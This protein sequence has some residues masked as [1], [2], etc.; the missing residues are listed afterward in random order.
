MPREKYRRRPQ[1]VKSVIH[2]GQRKLLLSE[3][4]FLTMYGRDGDVV[5]HAGAAPGN[6]TAYLAD[7]FSTMNFVLVDPAPFSP[8]LK[9]GEKMILR[10]ELFTDE[11]AHEYANQDVLFICDIRST[12]WALE[13]ESVVEDKVGGDME[14]QMRWH[15]IMKPRKSMLKFRLS[16]QP[17]TTEY[18]AGDMYLPVWG[19]ITTTEARLIPSEGLTMYD[20]KAYE[21]RVFFFNTRFR[22][23]R[24]K[25]DVVGEG[26]DYCYD[27]R[28][29]IDILRKYLVAKGLSSQP[30]D[31][32][33]MSRL[34]S[35]E[36]ARARTLVSPNGHPVAAVDP[37]RSGIPQ[38]RGP[39][40]SLL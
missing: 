27:C 6:H 36:C 5:V 11:I 31:I 15:Q 29:E 39:Q 32:A 33:A 12:D 37:G 35:R 7:L 19:P 26:R 3:I 17:G 1:E 34:A 2:W 22:V 28:S 25:H 40:A 8:K 38:T 9:E 4:E 10:Q 21:E 24:Y 13:D 18:L 16:W 30:A 23:G 20:N 14:A